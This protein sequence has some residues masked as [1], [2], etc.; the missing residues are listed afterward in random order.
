LGNNT[1]QLLINAPTWP[2]DANEMEQHA[3]CF[4]MTYLKAAASIPKGLAPKDP[5][6]E[7]TTP[8]HHTHVCTHIGKKSAARNCMSLGTRAA[9]LCFFHVFG[10]WG[11]SVD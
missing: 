11:F 5:P 2:N 3:L 10:D 6:M 9:R 7:S 1:I 8:H 4:G